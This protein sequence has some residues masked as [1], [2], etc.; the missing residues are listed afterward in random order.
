MPCAGPA[1]PGLGSP[2]RAR[3]EEHQRQSRKK[4]MYKNIKG[5]RKYPGWEQG[6]RQQRQAQLRY[7]NK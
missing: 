5:N 7:T 3:V 1:A 4:K 6:R 2:W